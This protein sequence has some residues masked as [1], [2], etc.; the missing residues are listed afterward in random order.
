MAVL[1]DNF[2]Q[3]RILPDGAGSDWLVAHL[4]TLLGPET[5]HLVR[6]E[7]GES[8][9]GYRHRLIATLSRAWASR[10]DPRQSGTHGGRP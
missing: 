10:R 6:S 8:A 3:A 5:W 4:Y 2:T 1:A 9:D 7:L